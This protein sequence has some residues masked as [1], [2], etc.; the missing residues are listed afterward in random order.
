MYFS[1]PSC[2][3]ICMYILLSVKRTW[4]L[5]QEIIIT[6]LF[7]HLL[8][9]LHREHLKNNITYNWHI[10]L[11]VNTVCPIITTI[12]GRNLLIL[13]PCLSVQKPI[14]ETVFFQCASFVWKSAAMHDKTAQN[15]TRVS[16]GALGPKQ[17]PDQVQLAI[18][19]GLEI[20]GRRRRCCSPV[21]IGF[22]YFHVFRS[23][24]FLH[25]REIY[26]IQDGNTG[27]L[28]GGILVSRGYEKMNWEGVFSH[29]NNGRVID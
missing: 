1:V 26:N 20:V 10:H 9:F 11:D 13:F 2:T 16:M 25:Y 6:S 5:L 19:E 8:V 18:F 14:P 17:P 27:F 3:R 21:V 4:Q 24:Y 23:V 15:I 7:I 28:C 12:N 22:D 29:V